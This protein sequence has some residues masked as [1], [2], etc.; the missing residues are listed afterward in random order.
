MVRKIEKENERSVATFERN[1][2]E[3]ALHELEGEGRARKEVRTFL[4]FSQEMETKEASVEGKGS[5]FK[6]PN[7]R[8]L[9]TVTGRGL[10]GTA[11]LYPKSGY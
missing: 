6:S 3:L 7:E 2:Q 4:V 5:Q 9:P 1:F 10:L 8:T 11:G